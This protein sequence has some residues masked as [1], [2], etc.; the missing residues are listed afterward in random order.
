M[1]YLLLSFLLVTLAVA[2]TPAVTPTITLKWLAM[3]TM[4]DGSPIP[5]GQ[6]A[7]YNIY[8]G[9]TA[10]GPWSAPINVTT[11]GSVR[12]GVALGVDCYYITAV[13][14]KVE[15]LPVTP[16][17]VTVAEG[18]VSTVPGTPTGFTATQTQ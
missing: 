8:G 18:T 15:G 2:Q 3:T 12:T 14:N 6:S 4:S 13:V 11:V 16:A 1:K 10:T 17:C 7:S 9:H 5:A